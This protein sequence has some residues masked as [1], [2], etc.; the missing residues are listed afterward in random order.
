MAVNTDEA[1]LTCSPLTSCCV[2][3]LVIGHIC[4][5]SVPV[6]WGPKLYTITLGREDLCLSQ[7]F[8]LYQ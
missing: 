6:G 1:L 8:K 2:A 3:Q 7:A 4:Y 5:Q